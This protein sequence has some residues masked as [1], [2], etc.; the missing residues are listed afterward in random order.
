MVEEWAGSEAIARAVASTQFWP[1]QHYGQ[2][3]SF[4]TQGL[5]GVGQRLHSRKPTGSDPCLSSPHCSVHRRTCLRKTK[6]KRCL[7]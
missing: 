2:A 1:W 6:M 7:R 3:H 4:Q 5:R